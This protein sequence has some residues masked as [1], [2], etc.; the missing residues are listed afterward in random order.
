GIG[1]LTTLGD[2]AS[3]SAREAGADFVLINPLHAAE[4]C[5]PVEDSP[6]L[7]TTRRYANPLYI[8]VEMIPEF[9]HLTEDLAAALRD[10]AAR[11]RPLNHSDEQIDRNPI[12]AAKLQALHAI[13]HIPMSEVRHADYERFL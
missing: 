9:S 5:P 7:P 3:V 13:R 1:D 8:R 6:Y 2:L 12:Y 11:F 4:P 10:M